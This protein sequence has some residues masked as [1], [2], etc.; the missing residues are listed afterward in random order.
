MG[1]PLIRPVNTGI[2]P[3]PVLIFLKNGIPV[4][5]ID[6]G[7]EDIESGLNL[8]SEQVTSLKTNPSFPHQL[9]LC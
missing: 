7:T 1:K 4:Y 8:P 2:M 6:S 9:T 3:E 5:L